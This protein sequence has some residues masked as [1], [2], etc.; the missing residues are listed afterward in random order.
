MAR[1]NNSLVEKGFGS[2]PEAHY[3]TLQNGFWPR[4]RWISQID[5]D[6]MGSPLSNAGDIEEDHYCG[7]RNGRS[8]T[9]FDQIIHVCKGM[10]LLIRPDDEDTYPIWLG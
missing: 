6:T 9:S 10:F 8:K 2:S 5:E 3:S 7:P 4:T 1:T